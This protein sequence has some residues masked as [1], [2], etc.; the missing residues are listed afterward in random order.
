MGPTSHPFE[1]QQ[2]IFIVAQQY[3]DRHVLHTAPQGLVHLRMVTHCMHEW[4]GN[5]HAGETHSADAAGRLAEGPDLAI[6]AGAEQPI[7][8]ILVLADLYLFGVY[9][10]ANTNLAWYDPCPLLS[11]VGYMQ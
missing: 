5:L 4:H 2:L 8:A 10:P 7:T 11:A 9:V 3:L 6:A 1:G